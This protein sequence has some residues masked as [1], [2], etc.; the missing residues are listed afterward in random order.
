M[1]KPET[2]TTRLFS[3]IVVLVAMA[4]VSFQGSKGISAIS[5]MAKTWKSQSCYLEYIVNALIVKY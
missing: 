2:E 3:G 5:V 4:E 1:P